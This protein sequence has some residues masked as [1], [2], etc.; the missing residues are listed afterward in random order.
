MK[1]IQ[2]YIAVLFLLLS[3]S[4]FASNWGSMGQIATYNPDRNEFL[5]VYTYVASN[6]STYEIRGRI[7]SGMGQTLSTELSLVT[8][9]PVN[10]YNPIGIAYNSAAKQY[11]VVYGSN[12]SPAKVYGLLVE[13]GTGAIM[14]SPTELGQGTSPS[15]AYDELS[16][17]YL[18]IWVDNAGNIV[19]GSY[20]N[21]DL[22]SVSG[23]YTIATETGGTYLYHTKANADG[24]GNFS[25]TYYDSYLVRSKF[26]LFPSLSTSF[27]PLIVASSAYGSTFAFNPYTNEY[28]SAARLSSDSSVYSYLF[29]SGTQSFNSSLQ[30]SASPGT[31]SSHYPALAY[32]PL[33]ARYALSY[34]EAAT[35]TPKI[36]FLDNSFTLIG[37][38]FSLSG[39]VSYDSPFINLT[40]NPQCG[41]FLA[42]WA[43]Q[44]SGQN[45]PE[46]DFIDGTCAGFVA[47]M[48][49]VLTF[50]DT[51]LAT[52]TDLSVTVTAKLN[53]I[54][55]L[56]FG[57]ADPEIMALT[58]SNAASFSILS[59]TC[60]PTELLENSSCTVTVRFTPE[61]LGEATAELMITDTNSS[62]IGGVSLI[63][64]AVDPLPASASTN[65]TL[66]LPAD[67]ATGQNPDRALVTWKKISHSGVTYK[68]T[69]CENQDF[70]GCNGAS[71][72][73]R[74]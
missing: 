26:L 48:P 42:S 52:S 40:A 55:G 20:L 69:V 11:L 31:S 19:S 32:N 6:Y 14:T 34:V 15:V 18:V 43:S 8:G 54:F 4:S 62:V 65:I 28:A 7:L 10:Y 59:H 37:T 29:D 44:I 58:A 49:E 9:M 45:I 12:E 57:I 24:L 46:F 33:N 70:S 38:P 5:A 3:G 74:D 36:N 56:G 50:P 23:T 47:A 66:S 64:H 72:N 71:P 16:G 17:K 21:S 1:T 67:G 27:S 41:G 25:V 61:T 30:V 51:P 53:S 63:A 13:P 68:V 35:Y 73:A 39:Q 22:T 2:T 60:S